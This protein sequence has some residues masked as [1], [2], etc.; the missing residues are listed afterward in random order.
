VFIS[1]F[2]FRYCFTLFS[3]LK[4]V[5]ARAGARCGSI[6]TESS[7]FV[8]ANICG[9]SSSSDW[10][11]T[12]FDRK[13]AIK[14]SKAS[15]HFLCKFCQIS[16]PALVHF[17]NQSFQIPLIHPQIRFDTTSFLDYAKVNG[18]QAK[19]FLNFCHRENIWI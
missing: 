8:A 7:Y 17:A 1:V 2:P 15:K 10:A 4:S 6:L 9:F 19:A 12:I 16:A 3:T 18:F 13:I 5:A 11:V 14:P